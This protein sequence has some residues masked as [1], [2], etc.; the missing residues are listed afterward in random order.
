MAFF[1][2][3]CRY[4]KKYSTYIGAIGANGFVEKI[5]TKRKLLRWSSA[6][7]GY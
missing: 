6:L 4:P 2:Y 7:R 1:F 5:Y 3:I